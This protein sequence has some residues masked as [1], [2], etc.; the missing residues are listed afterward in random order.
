[1]AMLDCAAAERLIRAHVVETPVVR[2]GWFSTASGARGVSQ[3]RESA[4]DGLLQAAWRY[5]QAALADAPRQR[6]A[7]S[8]LPAVAITR[9]PLRRPRRGSAW[10]RKSSCRR[11][12]IRA[13]REDRALGATVRSSRATHCSPSRRRVARVS[14]PAASTF[15]LTTISP[16]SPARAR[17]GGAVASITAS[18]GGVRRRRR[19]RAD[20]RHR[21]ASEG[22]FAPHRG[23]R[24]LARQLA[25]MFECLRAGRV[26]AVEEKPTVSVST[27]GGLE[28]GAV[29]LSL[30]REVIDR[31][32]LVSEEEILDSLRRSYRDDGQLVEGAA[33]VPSPRFARS[34]GITRARRSRLCSVA[35][36]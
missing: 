18:R 34:R 10:S 32:V 33:G 19:R 20:Q 27:A 22:G 2:C 31:S 15:R 24:L 9:R 29:T 17:F 26:I 5:A 1:M 25:A 14:A 16:S 36:T 21:R 30:C 12:S 13:A 8:P 11:R 35:G 28:D 23:R 6:A 3:A 7:S 4:G